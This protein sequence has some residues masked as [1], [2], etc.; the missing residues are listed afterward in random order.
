MVQPNSAAV[1][2]FGGCA[3]TN[4]LMTGVMELQQSLTTSGGV[5]M[6]AALK[7]AKEAAERASDIDAPDLVQSLISNGGFDFAAVTRAAKAAS[8]SC[9][10]QAVADIDVS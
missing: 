7:A 8:S 6:A 1:L 9:D 2:I 5:D 10:C 3:S 4:S